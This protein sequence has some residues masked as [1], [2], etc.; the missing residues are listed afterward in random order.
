LAAGFFIDQF[1]LAPHG[2]AADRA[3]LLV[4]TREDQREMASGVRGAQ[5]EPARFEVRWLD[6][7]A[8]EEQWVTQHRLDVVRRDV[9]LRVLGLIAIVPIEILRV[10]RETIQPGRCLGIVL[11]AHSYPIGI[12]ARRSE[13]RCDGGTSP[14]SSRN[15]SGTGSSKWSET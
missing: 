1:L 15:R 6:D 5:H 11:Q 7:P 9:V 8:G 14:R 4:A 12:I 2:A 13:A 3:Q 10:A